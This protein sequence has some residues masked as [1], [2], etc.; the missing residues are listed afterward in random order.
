M[1][2]VAALWDKWVLFCSIIHKLVQIKPCIHLQY[3]VCATQ[4]VN[5]RTKTFHFTLIYKSQSSYRLGREINM[6]YTYKLMNNLHT[7]PYK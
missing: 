5:E 6:K 4:N 7:R 3:F 2:G 1:I